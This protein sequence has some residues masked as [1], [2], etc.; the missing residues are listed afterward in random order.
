MNMDERRTWLACFEEQDSLT[1]TSAITGSP[2]LYAYNANAKS[3]A[4]VTIIKDMFLESKKHVFSFF[5]DE[6]N[7]LLGYICLAR[8][9]QIIIN[10]Y[11]TIIRSLVVMATT[12]MYTTA[13]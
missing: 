1:F 10:W 12:Q 3:A 7:L 4:S 13:S 11:Y 8:F 2:A 6:K 5:S 9:K